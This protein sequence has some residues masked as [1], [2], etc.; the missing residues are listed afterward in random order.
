M[1][2]I[3]PPVTK[4]SPRFWLGSTVPEAVTVA[5]TGPCATAV[6]ATAAALLLGFRAKYEPPAA[7]ATTSTS[8]PLTH[9]LLRRQ[10]F[11][12]IASRFQ[13]EPGSQEPARFLVLISP[14]RVKLADCEVYASSLA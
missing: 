5:S 13:I 12:E 10:I 11:T 7:T 9:R 3:L 14:N 1:A 2:V 8:G 4:F 6:V